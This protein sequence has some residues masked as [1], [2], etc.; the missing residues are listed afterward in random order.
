MES[1][2][3]EREVRTVRMQLTSI[4]SKLIIPALLL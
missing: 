1:L 3:W 4:T 2:G